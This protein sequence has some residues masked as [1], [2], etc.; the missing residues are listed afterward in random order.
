[1]AGVAPTLALSPPEGVCDFPLYIGSYALIPAKSPSVI[2]FTLAVGFYFLM[3][4]ASI[5]A[6]PGALIAFFTVIILASAQTSVIMSQSKFFSRCPPTDWRGLLMAWVLGIVGGTVGFWGAWAASGIG[7]TLN[8]GATEKFTL[9]S[10]AL[11]L[12]SSASTSAKQTKTADPQT[13]A[14]PGAPGNNTMIFEAV[15]NGVVDNT[16]IAEPIA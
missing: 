14:V 5:N 4:L 8:I 2:V 10:G 15:R 7:N 1:M 12:N 13:C 9:T 3:G 11:N 6:G 16:I